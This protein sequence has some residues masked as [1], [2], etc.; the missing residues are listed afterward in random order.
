MQDE[1]RKK[2]LAE[3][4]SEG[5]ASPHTLASYLQDMWEGLDTLEAQAG[6]VVVA[7]AIRKMAK[8]G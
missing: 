4:V 8:N 1:G 7:E 2:K 3:L 5:L 6:F